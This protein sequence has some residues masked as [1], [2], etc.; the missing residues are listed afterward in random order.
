M[1]QQIYQQTYRNGLTLLL[2]RMDHVRSAAVN[3]L[4]PA[5]C[6]YDPPERLGLV[7]ILSDM[8]TRGAGDRDS[9]ALSLAMDS[10]GLDHSESVGQLHLRF[11]GSTLARSIPAALEI[12]PIPPPAFS[13]RG[14]GLRQGTGTARFAVARRRTAVRKSWSSCGG[15]F[16]PPR[17]GQDRRGTKE[18]IESITAGDLRAFHLARFNPQGII[19]SV[20]GN[21]EWEPLRRPVENLFGDWQGKKVQTPALKSPLRGQTHLP[22]D[23]VQ[24][25]IVI[26]YPSVPFGHPE[27]YDALGAVQILSGGMGARL[28]TEVREKRRPVL[29]RQAI[30][31]IQGGRR[32]PLLRRA[33]TK[34]PGNAR[35]DRGR[36]KRSSTASARKKSG[37]VRAGLKSSVIMQEESTSGTR[38][39]PGI[40]TGIT[41]AGYAPSR[42][43]RPPSTPCRRRASS[44]TYGNTPSRILP[45]SRSART[46]LRCHSHNRIDLAKKSGAKK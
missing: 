1:P 9:R 38:R 30:P 35:R 15:A 16:G 11:W 40:A 44:S 18:S 36:V 26:A 45:S 46:H 20:A 27:Y 23:T 43:S 22:K 37:A 39:H 25:Q 32:H 41:S 19:L 8:I 24:T 2:E 21:I 10:L 33:T 7:S 5:G 12:S 17:S 42:K 6:V 3:F 4:V 14:N 31:D 29:C 34:Q 13:G 28:F